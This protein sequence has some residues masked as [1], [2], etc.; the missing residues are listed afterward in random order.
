MTNAGFRPIDR[1]PRCW[2]PRSCRP[3]RWIRRSPW[4]RGWGCHWAWLRL[5]RR[6]SAG[7]YPNPFGCRRLAACRSLE[8]R[9]TPSQ[10]RHSPP[11]PSRILFLNPPTPWVCRQL[12]SFGR[13]E[14]LDPSARPRVALPCRV[15]LDF[16]RL[17]WADWERSHRPLADSCHLPTA[18]RHWRI[19]HHWAA[20]DSRFPRPGREIQRPR[21]DFVHETRRRFLASD[22]PDWSVWQGRI[23]SSLAASSDP[24]SPRRWHWTSQAKAA[25]FAA[26]G[27]GRPRCSSRLENS[28]TILEGRTKHCPRGFLA[29]GRNRLGWGS[30][31]SG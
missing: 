23:R 11:W 27:A 19:C 12:G 30:L 24:T 6:G 10:R 1:V 3:L 22:W 21:S 15:R 16:L 5:A 7:S 4:S 28:E 26:D 20:G 25:S 31:D 2:R 13:R 9:T 18:Y 14:R 17:R 29:R 8:S